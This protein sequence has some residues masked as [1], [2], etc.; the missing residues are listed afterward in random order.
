MHSGFSAHF[1][2]LGY[3]SIKDEC[4]SAKQRLRSRL[5]FFIF[6]IYILE[7]LIFLGDLIIRM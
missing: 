1:W 7:I 6:F 2:V 5:S 3:K 4:T